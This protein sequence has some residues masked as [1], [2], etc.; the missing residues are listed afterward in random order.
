MEKLKMIF[1]G[2]FILLMRNC[3]F[4]CFCRIL[5]KKLSINQ[6][7]DQKNESNKRKMK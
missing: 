5:K 3:L 4:I 1:S 2:Q 7:V 6:C